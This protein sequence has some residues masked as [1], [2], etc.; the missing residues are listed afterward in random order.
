M[1]ARRA[2]NLRR[3]LALAWPVFVGQLAV[4]GFSTVDT[5]LVA[6]ASPQDLAAMSVGA[7]IYV[8]VFIGMMGVVLAIGPIVGQ[9]F[10]A[11]DRVQ[12]GRQL[13]QAA[14]IALGLSPQAPDAPPI[15]TRRSLI[16]ASAAQ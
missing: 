14:W 10:G 16:A 1:S 2:Q 7:S 9:L 6:R 11:G 15:R 8:T 3:I 12:A 5:L 4:V 13:H